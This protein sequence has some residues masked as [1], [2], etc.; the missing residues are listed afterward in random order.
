MEWKR[1]EQ[2]EVHAGAKTAEHIA[3][4]FPGCLR[5][6]ASLTAEQRAGVVRTYCAYDRHITRPERTPANVARRWALLCDGPA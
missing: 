1:Q 6:Y 3:R 5:E 4:D 2:E